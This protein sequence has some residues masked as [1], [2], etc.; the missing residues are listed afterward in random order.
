VFPQI[1]CTRGYNRP[2]EFGKINLKP[3][4]KE[5]NNNKRLRQNHNL[6]WNKNNEA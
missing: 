6:S 3:I 4:K 2:T 5:N 1:Y